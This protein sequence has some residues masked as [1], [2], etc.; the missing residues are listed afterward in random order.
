MVIYCLLFL[1]CFLKHLNGHISWFFR[2]EIISSIM[3]H[4][5]MLSNE[6]SFFVK[7]GG[8]NFWIHLRLYDIAK[9][10]P[11]EYKVYYRLSLVTADYGFVSILQFFNSNVLMKFGI[12]TVWCSAS[13][14]SHIARV[15]SLYVNTTLITL[16]N[17][18][19]KCSKFDFFFFKKHYV[20]KKVFVIQYICLN[21]AVRFRGCTE[22]QFSAPCGLAGKK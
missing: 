2:R 10:V 8:R 5:L 6:G 9:N 1:I 4:H 14:H 13:F 21:K 22:V 17:K 15:S 3:R 7:H 12:K 20:P 16:I 11:S 19:N 18:R